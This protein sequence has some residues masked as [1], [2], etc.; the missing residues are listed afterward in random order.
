MYNGTQ[1]S[2][3]KNIQGILSQFN[4]FSQLASKEL[5]RLGKYSRILTFEKGENI[6]IEGEE[7]CYTWV[8]ESGRLDIYKYTTEGKPHAIETILQG[9]LF[10]ALCR[11]GGSTKTY[12][13]TAIAAQKS[14]AIQIPDSLFFELFDTSPRFVTGVCTLCSQRLKFMQD[15]SCAAQEP[16]EKRIARTLIE[17]SK[18]H[19]TTLHVTKREIAE[20]SGTTVETTIRTMG[21]FQKSNWISSSRGK[22]TL[23][24]KT[25]IQ[26]LL[27]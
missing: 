22:I 16:V 18:R 4:P 8:L 17:F 15:M 25:R 20:F 6:Y 12:P 1:E 2:R 7:A 3:V 27:N 21:K 26:A 14:T 23:V 19:G 11:L 5:S 13:C 9:D 24:N 10:G